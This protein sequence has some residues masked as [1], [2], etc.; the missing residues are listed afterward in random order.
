MIHFY[1]KLAEFLKLRHKIYLHTYTQN[2]LYKVSSTRRPWPY[3]CSRTVPILL[4]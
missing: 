2:I 3:C 4:Y 1:K